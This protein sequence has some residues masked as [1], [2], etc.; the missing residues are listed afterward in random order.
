MGI[1]IKHKKLR[2]KPK[3]QPKFLRWL[4]E[5]E[6]PSCMVCGTKTGVQ[7]HH[8]KNHSTDQRNDFFII[9]LCYDHHL[10]NELSPHGTPSVFKEKYP[11]DVQK[12]HANKLYK[13]YKNERL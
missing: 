11:L 1:K 5:V 10:G 8:I 4:H 3:K 12:E 13:R 2:P 9:P 6:Q 7:M